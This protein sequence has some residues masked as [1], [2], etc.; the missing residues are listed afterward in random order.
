MSSAKTI[1]SSSM[2]QWVR[3]ADGPRVRH[4]AEAYEGIIDGLTEIVSDSGRNPN[5]KRQYRVK[6][7]TST[8]MLVSED[9]LNIL[10]DQEK[11]VLV[12]RESEL[13]RRRTTE[14]LRSVFAEDPICGEWSCRPG[15]STQKDVNG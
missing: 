11:L 13:Y 12:A 15:L 10:L 1:S 6:V 9:H 3:I 14:R 8:R 2:N 5:G 4:R 7:D